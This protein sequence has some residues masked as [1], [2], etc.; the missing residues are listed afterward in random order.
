MN[1]EH[2][3]LLA[4][5]AAGGAA[6]SPVQL[7]KSLFLLGRELSDAVGENYYVFQPY[8]F[9]PFDADVYHDAEKLAAQGLVAIHREPWRSWVEYQATP[10]GL[11]YARKIQTEV[12][13]EAFA[14]LRKTVAW[15]Q[16]LSF[17]ALVRSIYQRYPE[18]R[19]N[20]VFQ[21]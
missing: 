17:Q 16:S 13:P 15:A 6:L 8:N 21:D 3:T 10:A 20:S 14:Y 12:A 18:F 9:G 11:K 19:A 1:R 5:S 7:Q 2:W 4:L